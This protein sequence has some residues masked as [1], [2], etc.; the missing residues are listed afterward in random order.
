M[1]IPIGLMTGVFSMYYNYRTV[2]LRHL[3]LKC[4]DEKIHSVYKQ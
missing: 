4:N 3:G 1:R 2:G